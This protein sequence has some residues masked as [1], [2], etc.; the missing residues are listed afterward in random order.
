MCGYLFFIGVGVRGAGGEAYGPGCAAHRLFCMQASLC[1]RQQ[2][3]VTAGVSA[4][5]W[6]TLGGS[7]I[8]TLPP[9][10]PG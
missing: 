8:K 6:G 2:A 5:G 4:D 1:G 9:S 7:W 10:L 3:G